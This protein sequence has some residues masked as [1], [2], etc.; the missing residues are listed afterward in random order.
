MRQLFEM[1]VN[2]SNDNVSATGWPKNSDRKTI[3]VISQSGRC[4]GFSY[5]FS[6]F[7]ILYICWIL[8]DS[9]NL[10]FLRKRDI[11]AKKN[12]ECSSHQVYVSSMIVFY[13]VEVLHGFKC[14]CIAAYASDSYTI[15]QIYLLLFLHYIL[16]SVWELCSN[17]ANHLNPIPW[18]FFL[19]FFP[20]SGEIVPDFET[21][22]FL[23]NWNG[24][25]LLL[26]F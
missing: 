9:R 22:T 16:Q 23:E 21:E 13:Y 4:T 18:D 6:L 2:I 11:L 7:S 10:L 5:I 26:I 1:V 15:S 24:A 3:R 19:I 14:C 20:L 17:S 8:L 25:P 12:S